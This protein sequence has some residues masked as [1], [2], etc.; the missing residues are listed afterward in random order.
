[1]MFATSKSAFR[2]SSCQSFL[3]ADRIDLGHSRRSG[4]YLLPQSSLCRLIVVQLRVGLK[5]TNKGEAIDL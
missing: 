1:M 2:S 3:Q 5:V 4:D